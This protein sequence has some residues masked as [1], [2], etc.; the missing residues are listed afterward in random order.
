MGLFKR[1]LA[2]RVGELDENVTALDP[3][4]H[5]GI[6]LLNGRLEGRVEIGARGRRDDDLSRKC[7]EADDITLYDLRGPGPGGEVG[8]SADRKQRHEQNGGDPASRS[9]PVVHTWAVNGGRCHLV[10]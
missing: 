10:S 7:Y 3:R 8:P 6:D 4:S 2:R 1:E 5:R 9:G